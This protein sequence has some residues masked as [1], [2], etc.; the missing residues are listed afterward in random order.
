MCKTLDFSESRFQVCW[1]CGLM[2]IGSIPGLFKDKYETISASAFGTDNQAGRLVTV[3]LVIYQ[4]STDQDR[5]TLIDAFQKGQS[6]G[7]ADA[8]SK[9]K[10]VGHIDV[11]GTMGFD[12]S[13]IR[14]IQTPTGRKIRFITNRKIAFGEARSESQSMSFRSYSRRIRPE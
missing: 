1:C 7:L 3:T 11:T 2:M 13:F 12:V 10:A 5:Q 9:M 14:M 6:Q 4:F 8:L